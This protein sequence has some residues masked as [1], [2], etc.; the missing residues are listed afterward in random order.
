MQADRGDAGLGCRPGR[1]LVEDQRRRT[2]LGTFTP[3]HDPAPG[4]AFNWTC[5]AYLIVTDTGSTGTITSNE[6][7]TRAG[8]STIR[9][10]DSFTVDT[11]Q[12]NDVV[13]T[14]SWRSTAGSPTITCDGTVLERLQNYPAQLARLCPAAGPD[15]PAA[16]GYFG[17]KRRA[18]SRRMTSPFR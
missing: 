6:T 13:L 3:A 4:A 5:T 9:G 17:G 16:R 8:Q 1:P 12:A 10:N 15:D 14:A 2:S 11:T 7:F 18:P